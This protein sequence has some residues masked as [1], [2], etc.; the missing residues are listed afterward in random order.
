MSYLEFNYLVQN[1]KAVITDSGGI[2]EETT[3]MNVP[4]I[5]LRNSTER[6]E[7]IEIGTNELVG[8]DPDKIKLAMLKI[9][10]GNW[11]K[12]SVPKFWDGLTADRIVRHISNFDL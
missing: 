2:S 10:S 6:P 7:T 3:V 1:A 5:T 12:G 9:I 11:K 4:C 8:T